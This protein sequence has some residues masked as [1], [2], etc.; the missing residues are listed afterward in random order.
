MPGNKSK[1]AI[2]VVLEDLPE[3]QTG[4]RMAAPLAGKI[5]KKALDLGY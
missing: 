4:G 1:L 2:A 3:G 5:F